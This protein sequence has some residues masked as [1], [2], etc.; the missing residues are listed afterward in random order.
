[1]DVPASA[2]SNNEQYY[3]VSRAPLPPLPFY[4]PPPFFSF[5][6]IQVC[7]EGLKAPCSV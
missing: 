1:M 2:P 6:S 7:F 4:P 3:D 5:Y